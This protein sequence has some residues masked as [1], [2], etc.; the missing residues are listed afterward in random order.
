VVGQNGL[1]RGGCGFQR[2]DGLL[3]PLQRGAMLLENFTV[4]HLHFG[5]DF[6]LGSVVLAEHS[7]FLDFRCQG[8]QAL[9]DLLEPPIDLLEPPID[10]LEP[11]IHP[12][13]EQFQA[14][15][16]RTEPR[17]YVWHL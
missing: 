3:D 14:L 5:D 17:V 6:D 4:M 15:F 12:C 10:L 8:V 9:V 2:L 16:H 11:F 1:E 7:E 13:A